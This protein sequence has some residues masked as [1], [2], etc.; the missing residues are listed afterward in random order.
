MFAFVLGTVIGMVVVGGFCF[1]AIV[2]FGGSVGG[3]LAVAGFCALFEG[4]GFGGTM[5]FVLHQSRLERER[6]DARAG[7]PGTR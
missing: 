5:G 6:S 1:G 4:P 2:L 3:A 7:I